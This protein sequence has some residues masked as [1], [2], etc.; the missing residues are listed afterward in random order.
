ME[1]DQQLDRSI[2]ENHQMFAQYLKFWH[3]REY[4]EDNEGEEMKAIES[5]VRLIDLSQPCHGSIQYQLEITEIHTN[6]LSSAL[7]TNQ[8]LKQ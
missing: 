7:Q 6:Y 1:S 2:G 8:V 4:K 3:H 5:L